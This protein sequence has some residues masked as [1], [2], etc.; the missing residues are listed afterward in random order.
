MPVK[1]SPKTNLPICSKLGYLNFCFKNIA[2][3]QF[4]TSF[5]SIPLCFDVDIFASRKSIDVG[6]LGLQNCLY[7]GPMGFSKIWLLFLEFSGNSAT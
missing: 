1:K 7:V 6:I 2:K 5:D 4:K 3:N